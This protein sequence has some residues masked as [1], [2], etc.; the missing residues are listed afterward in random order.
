MKNI[1]NFLNKTPPIH[2]FFPLHRSDGISKQILGEYFGNSKD[3]NQ[4]VLK[5]FCLMLD[6]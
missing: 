3:Y 5:A 4:S 2:P 1:H 6:F